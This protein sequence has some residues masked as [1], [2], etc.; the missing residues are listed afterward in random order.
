MGTRIKQGARTYNGSFQ[1]QG[2][3]LLKLGKT[4]AFCVWKSA[5]KSFREH[6]CKSKKV[7]AANQV[8]GKFPAIPLHKMS[9]AVGQQRRMRNDQVLGQDRF[10]H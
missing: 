1:W 4:T 9:K 5:L 10:V 6:T 2:T 8:L 7:C 3:P